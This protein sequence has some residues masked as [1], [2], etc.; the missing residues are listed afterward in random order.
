MGE[1]DEACLDMVEGTND[2]VQAELCEEQPCP[3]PVGPP[4]PDLDDGVVG[5]T[6]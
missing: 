4:V 2:E 6:L 3:D 1:V 5:R